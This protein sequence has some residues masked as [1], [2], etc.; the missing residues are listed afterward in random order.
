M[1]SFNNENEFKRLLNGL[2][3]DILDA[4]IHYKLYKDLLE[5]SKE[6]PVVIP[7]SNTFWSLTLKSH[8]NTSLYALTRAYDQNNTALHLSSFL[9]TIK[10]N[11]DLFS[12][13]KFKER[14]QDNQFLDSLVKEF[15]EPNL[16][17][18]ESD[19]L[20][21]SDDDALVNTLIIH[22]GQIL[23]HRNAKNA[24]KGRSPNETHP[25]TFEDFETLLKRAIIILNT[26]SQLFEASSYSTQIIGHS[27]FRF[28]FECVT[29]A[30]ENSQLAAIE[31]EKQFK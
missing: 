29:S 20:L 24:A 10:A 25:L 13:A 31:F 3:N 15:R 8:L 18:L 5:T 22:R 16:A 11:L 19:I 7:Q 12:S 1:I 2:S 21:C 9:K 30:V 6:F 28:I 27:D 26:Y 23:A 4:H 17:N 14:K